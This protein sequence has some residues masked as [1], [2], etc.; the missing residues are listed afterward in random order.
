VAAGV[1]NGGTVMQPQLLHQIIDPSGGVVTETRPEE[2]SKPMSER[3]ARILRD[4]MVA[5]VE[6]GTGTNARI[7]GIQVAGKTGTSQTVEGASP[8]AWFIAFAP[9]QNPEIAIA[10]IVEHGGSFGSE[11][12][13]GALAAPIAKRVIEADRQ[14]SQ[15]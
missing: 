11:A 7:P 14:I 15:W 3:T 2:M 12:T 4:M 9:A 1:A 8:H 13:G 6:T 10:V 5:V